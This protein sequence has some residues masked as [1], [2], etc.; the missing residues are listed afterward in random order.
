MIDIGLAPMAAAPFCAALLNAAPVRS[1]LC[2]DRRVR[3]PP[4]RVTWLSRVMVWP[5][6]MACCLFRGHEGKVA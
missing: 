4:E 3:P 1:V 6:T 2:P 5:L